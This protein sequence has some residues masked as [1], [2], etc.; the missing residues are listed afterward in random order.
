MHEF[1]N[2]KTGKSF[3]IP[4]DIE[5]LDQH[6]YLFY[7]EQ[8]LKFVNGLITDPQEIKRNLFNNFTDM[9]MGWKM[10][11]YSDEI[12][13]Q[14]W[15]SINRMIDTLDSFFDIEEKEDG[16]VYIMHINS[17][18][19]L[20]PEWN[21]Y[22]SYKDIFSE[23]TWGE[24]HKC[25]DLLKLIDI[26]IKNDKGTEVN[27]L[28]EELF[29]TL[30]KPKKPNCKIDK[31]H[32]TVLFHALNYFSYIYQLITTTPIE[33]N[34]EEIDFSVLWKYDE[35]DEENNSELKKLGWN[36]IQFIISEKGVF[37][38]SEQLNKEKFIN[39]FL[40]LYKQHID[41]KTEKK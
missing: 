28:M 9:K 31:I 7:L 24:F 3:S 27:N 10:K 25:S 17:A 21:G 16:K 41:N 34:G 19:N 15:D 26:G 4:S 35:E 23:M 40:W 22:E 32:Q 1:L 38:N 6:Q 2:L 30:Y 33:I 8:V 11:F 14:I 12:Y 18:K 20:L 29:Y 36:N 37:G 13:Y 5:E 39:V